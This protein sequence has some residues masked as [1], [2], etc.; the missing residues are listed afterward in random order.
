[1]VPFEAQFT[2][3]QRDPD[4]GKKLR[5][6]ASG[7]LNYALH[8]LAYYLANGMPESV[9]VT[10]WTDEYRGEMDTIA[11]FID[12][13]CEEGSS[14]EVASQTLYNQ[15]SNW[16][17]SSGHHAMSITSFSSQL[18]SKGYEKIHT[19]TGKKWLGIQVREYSQTNA[20]Y[21]QKD[22]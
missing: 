2:K 12:A 15:Y 14:Y 22:D 11:Q 5:A 10:E 8:G 13:E 7:I 19:K 6:E 18:T 21:W 16:C 17:K 9:K 4:L 20:N 1:M 3:G